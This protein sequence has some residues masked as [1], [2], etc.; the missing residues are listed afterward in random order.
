MYL[1]LQLGLNGVDISEKMGTIFDQE[2]LMEIM[3]TREMIDD[4]DKDSEGINSCPLGYL[5]Q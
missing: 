4:L 1:L 3:E 2:L 5:T